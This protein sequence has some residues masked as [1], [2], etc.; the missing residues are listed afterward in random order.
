MT[1]SKVPDTTIKDQV[2]FSPFRIDMACYESAGCRAVKVLHFCPRGLDG[3]PGPDF[4]G[5]NDDD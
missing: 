1:P 5:G 4:A 2:Q 3:L